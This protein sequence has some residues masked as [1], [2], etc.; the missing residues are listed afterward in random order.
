MNTLKGDKKMNN[1]STGREDGFTLI[2]ILVVIIII[3]ILA[4]IAVPIYL[5]QQRVAR[6]SATAQD[7]KNAAIAVET[8]LAQMPEANG[9]AFYLGHRD[10]EDTEIAARAYTGPASVPTEITD[11]VHF[12]K[13]KGTVITVHMIDEN[14]VP[15]FYP[16]PS[17]VNGSYRIVG[18]N[19][20]GKDY[21]D[22][23]VG[24][25]Y[26]SAHGGLGGKP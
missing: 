14:G 24:V 20:N 10:P 1:S 7:V 23:S 11:H 8:A 26:Y 22:S 3:G 18:W 15:A 19:A 6:D 16:N 5:N 25:R 4:A 13:S 21:T 9:V 2:E 12:T 17:V